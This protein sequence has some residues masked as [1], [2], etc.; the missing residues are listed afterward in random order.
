MRRDSSIWRREQ[1]TDISMDRRPDLPTKSRSESASEA[2][3]SGKKF[4]PWSQRWHGQFITQLSPHTTSIKKIKKHN[5]LFFYKNL[6]F[7]NIKASKCP[8]IKNIWRLQIIRKI[9]GYCKYLRYIEE[10]PYF[11]IITKL[12]YYF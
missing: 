10:I 7:K 1:L 8:K 3:L 5:T 2:E 12:C 11:S 6:V 4:I 9:F